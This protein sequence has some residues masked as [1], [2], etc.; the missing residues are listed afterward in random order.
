MHSN[1]EILCVGQDRTIREAIVL[2]DQNKQ[3]IVLAVDGQR[4]LVGTITDGDVRRAVLARINFD[5]PVTTLLARKS[6]TMYA[7]PITASV[8]ADPTTWLS[9]LREHSILHLPLLDDQQRVAGLATLDEFVQ[10]PSPAVRAVVMAGGRGSRLH[11][12]TEDL[13]KPMLLIGGQPLLEIIIRQ[14]RDAGIKQVKVTTCHKPEKIAEHFGDGK[15]FGVELSYVAEDRPMGTVGGLGLIAA[16]NETTLVING[17]IL[18]QVDF[19]AMLVYHREHKADLTVA[20]RH[21]DVKV[22]YGVIECQ[23]AAVHRL[24]E[25]PVFDFF[26][27]AGIYLLEPSVYGFIPNGQRLDM[28]ELIQRLLKQGRSVVSFPVREYWLDVGQ[29]A[30]YEEAQEQIKSWKSAT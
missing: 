2:M 8:T 25:K 6:S 9:V 20:V 27:N 16:P 24:N 22:P 28:T 11:P 3:G 17:D 21:Y 13:P 1:L 5:E 14:L 23:G 18:T 26:V 19:R 29:H 4:Q 30:D 10:G 7:K 15:N 12:L